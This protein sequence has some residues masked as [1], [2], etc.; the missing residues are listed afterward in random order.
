[1][2]DSAGT[3]YGFTNPEGPFAYPDDEIKRIVNSTDFRAGQGERGGVPPLGKNSQVARKF[4]D[5]FANPGGFGGLSPKEGL[6]GGQ[7]APDGLPAGADTGF[8]VPAAVI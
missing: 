1:M 6:E 8:P 3:H 4:R 2:R 5:R 7:F